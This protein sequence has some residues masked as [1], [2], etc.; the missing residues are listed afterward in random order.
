MTRPGVLPASLRF[1]PHSPRTDAL[2]RRHHSPWPRFTRA[3]GFPLQPPLHGVVLARPPHGGFD[4]LPASLTRSVFRGY[5]LRSAGGPPGP[6]HRAGSL[7]RRPRLWGARAGSVLCISVPGVATVRVPS[8][9]VRGVSP[10]G[11]TPQST[12]PPVYEPGPAAISRDRLADFL[13]DVLVRHHPG[14]RTPARWFPTPYS[15]LGLRKRDN[16]CNL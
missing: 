6:G 2:V 12:V 8:H 7:L 1:G 4:R 9:P 11:S 10:R 16:D 13:L 15:R 5:R 3:R 14:T